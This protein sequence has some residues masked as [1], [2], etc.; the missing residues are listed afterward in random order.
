MNKLFS[1]IPLLFVLTGL[2]AQAQV[3]S[4]PAKD[5]DDLLYS[6]DPV[7][8]ANKKLAYDMYR[9]VLEAGQ[10]DR[11]PH[12]VREDYIQHNPNVVTG[13]AALESF[14]AG[15]RPSRKAD[16]KIMLP[17]ISIIAERDLVMFNFVRTEQDANGE[18][19]Y[20]TWFDVFRIEDGLVVEHWDPALKRADALKFN[21]NSQRLKD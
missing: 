2:P 15:S 10:V 14:I 16:D 8:A 20:T 18:T 1:L 12:Y 5:Q 19:Y 6:A 4:E 17:L 21:P 13:R 3:R 7:L 9:E 11:I